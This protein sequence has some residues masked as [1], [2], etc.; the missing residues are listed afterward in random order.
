MK[1]P[2]CNNTVAAYAG[3]ALLKYFFSSPPLT[4]GSFS[5]FAAKPP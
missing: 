2:P 3:A 4:S 1:N 5:N